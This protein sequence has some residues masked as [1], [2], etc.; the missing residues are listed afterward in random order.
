M[1]TLV[2]IKNKDM[3]TLI[4]LLVALLTMGNIA[5]QTTLT[6]KVVNNENIPV[7]KAQIYLDSVDTGSV[8]ND[9]GFFQVEVPEGIKDI[10][11]F[12]KKYGLLSVAYDNNTFLKFMYLD[13]ELNTSAEKSEEEDNIK[14]GYGK[15][16]K[17]DNTQTA[18][19]V[20]IKDTDQTVGFESIFDMIRARVAGVRV[21]SSN[22]V[23]IR[24]VSTF[25]GPTQP[26]FVV[27][28]AIVSSIGFLTPFEVDEIT[29]LKGNAASMY[30]SRASNGVIEITT[31]K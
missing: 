29:V 12:S 13:P 24:G 23:F 2:V 19:Q 11:V 6:G 28:G 25:L 3:R 30:G 31:K 16:A 4:V 9:R 26:L 8:T 15:V 17:E 22:Q 1:A 14:I 18:A 27:D 21:T 7:V 10:H 20:G 5:A